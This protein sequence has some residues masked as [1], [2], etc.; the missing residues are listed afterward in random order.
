[1]IDW[2]HD[3]CQQWSVQYRMRE[4]SGLYP[5]LS[6]LTSFN[7]LH[8]AESLTE[9]AREVSEGVLLMRGTRDMG[10]AYRVLMAHELFPGTV[11]AK[12]RA[13]DTDVDTYYRD[14]HSAQCF[15]A[16][17]IKQPVPRGAFEATLI[18]TSLAAR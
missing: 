10:D 4:Y 18:A 6:D 9:G 3:R 14:L 8:N 1:M 11:K 12:A 7:Y 5:A 2:V 17:R 16:A 13:L 15:L